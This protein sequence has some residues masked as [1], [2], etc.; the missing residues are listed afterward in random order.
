[1]VSVVVVVI[2][3]VITVDMVV[4][5]IVIVVVVVVTRT[6]YVIYNCYFQDILSKMI[7]NK[8]KLKFYLYNFKY[9]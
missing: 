8:I 3:I 1:M 7:K 6:V 5:I 4:I 2:P 9:T